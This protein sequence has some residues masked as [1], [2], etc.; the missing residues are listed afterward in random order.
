MNEH[1]YYAALTDQKFPSNF[2]SS[3]L[4]IIKKHKRAKSLVHLL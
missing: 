2:K 1:K 4:M 3:I